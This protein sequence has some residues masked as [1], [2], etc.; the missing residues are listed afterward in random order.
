[1]TDATTPQ[2][3]P[4]PGQDVV[5]FHVLDDLKRRAEMGAKPENYGRYLET[6]NGRDMLWDAYHEAL[7]LCM[8]LRGELLQREA[9][10]RQQY[11]REM[12]ARIK[13]LAK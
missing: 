9:L 4:Q 3:P 2:P 7:D 1:M 5:L 13:E 12:Q 6:F 8:Y 10:Q 11:R